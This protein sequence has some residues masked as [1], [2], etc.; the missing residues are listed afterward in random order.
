M[1]DRLW[2]LGEKAQ[3]EL[4]DKK[5]K[6]SKEIRIDAMRDAIEFSQRTSAW[7]RGKAVLVFPAERMNVVSASALLKTLE[8]P[9]GDVKFVLASEAAHQLLPTIR[10]RCLGHAMVWPQNAEAIHWMVSKGVE[11]SAAPIL[12][13]ASGGRPDDAL[14]LA[15][16]GR[17]PALWALLPKAVQRGD[18]TPMQGWTPAE[19]V[20]ALHKIC[21]DLQLLGQGAKPRFFAPHDLPKPV[22]QKVLSQWG[23]SLAR[24]TRTMEHPF[25]PGLM[26]EAL[27]SEAKTALNSPH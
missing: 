22:S 19:T 21:H 9:V 18:M 6:P 17:D 4:D 20:H 12:L 10:S 8:E 5:R 15:N 7:G 13:R 25:N 24:T 26:Q 14:A 1:L 16:S 11:T 2:P 23:R 27:V 3:T